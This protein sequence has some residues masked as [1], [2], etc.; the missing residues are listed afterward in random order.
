MRPTR[1]LAL[2]VLMC[3]IWGTTWIAVKLGVAAVPPCLFA[4]TR[5]VVA[6]G[7]LLLVLRLRGRPVGIARPDL[8]RLAAVT[9]LMVVATY[10]LLFW[11]ARSVSSGIAAILDL[12]LMP[13]ALLGIGAA[14]GEER[15]TRARV[16]GVALGVAGL[17]VLFAPRL[18][19]E[20]VGNTSLVGAGAIVLAALVYSLGSVAARPLL[21]AYPPVL[22]AGVTMLA[23][24][25]V[26]IALSAAL[27][28]GAGRA[29]AL[30]WGAAAWGS[31]AF[32]VLFGSLGAY[33]IYLHLIQVWGPA[34][35]GAYAFVSPAIAVL[36]GMVALGEHFGTVEAVGMAMMLA[37]AALALREPDAV[38]D[39]GRRVR[40]GQPRTRTA[41]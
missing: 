41:V 11:G 39:R 12:A 3:A 32:L 29:L 36:L 5:F 16:A 37:G 22:L 40:V 28:P 31:W 30:R 25:V 27:E 23:G 34:R 1:S 15:L 26:L 20:G 2:F 17:L 4:G 6:G 7:F 8:G 33:T 13:V 19:A 14:F 18:A 35:A 21:R 9:L 24:G 38:A 10:A